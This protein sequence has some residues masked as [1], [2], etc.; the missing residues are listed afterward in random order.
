MDC[1]NIYLR[2]LYE[3]NR[4]ET[5]AAAIIIGR[6]FIWIRTGRSIKSYRC[7]PIIQATKYPTNMPIKHEFTTNTNASYMYILA[8]RCF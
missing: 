4:L 2:G 6:P 5:I 1:E 7:S 8:T 3:L